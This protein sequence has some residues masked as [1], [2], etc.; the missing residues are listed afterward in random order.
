L[1]FYPFFALKV[2]GLLGFHVLAHWFAYVL[3]K[4]Y[5]ECASTGNLGNFLID[6]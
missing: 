5:R 1:R 6:Q 4:A 3:P 2:R